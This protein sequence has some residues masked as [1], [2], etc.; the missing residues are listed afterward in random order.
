MC[1]FVWK[2][3]GCVY[4]YTHRG[5][6]RIWLFGMFNMVCVIGL[7]DAWL[8][9]SAKRVR[10]LYIYLTNRW[11]LSKFKGRS[12]SAGHRM[13]TTLYKYNPSCVYFLSASWPRSHS[14]T[15]FDPA[16]LTVPNHGA[17]ILYI[18]ID[19]D[20]DAKR[21]SGFDVKVF[22]FIPAAARRPIHWMP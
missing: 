9:P 10:W 21:L 18:Y 7:E 8:E 6:M 22:A 4:I 11:K 17:R 1:L 16:D 19:D 2:I 14:N 5:S 12:A 13:H 15:K 20:D 3:I